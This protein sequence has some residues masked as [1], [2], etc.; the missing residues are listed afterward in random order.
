MM[1]DLV[2]AATVTLVPMPMVLPV[3]C[4]QHSCSNQ[5]SIRNIIILVIIRYYY[6]I[7]N[8]KWNFHCSSDCYQALS[9][10]F[11]WKLKC[12]FNDNVFII[13]NYLKGWLSLAWMFRYGWK[14]WA[15]KYLRFSSCLTVRDIHNYIDDLQE[16]EEAVNANLLSTKPRMS[17]IFFNP[18]FTFY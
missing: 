16:I 11:V 10:I 7:I 12:Y 6:V 2:A 13:M 17:L 1:L 9:D 4:V 14:W 15:T 5:T 3:Q 8:L 18:C